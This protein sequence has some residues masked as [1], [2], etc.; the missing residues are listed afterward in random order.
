MG[1]AG[2][3]ACSFWDADTGTVVQLSSISQDSSFSISDVYERDLDG[4]R[5]RTMQQFQLQITTYQPNGIEQL[6]K[7]A[8]ENTKLGFILAG[9]QENILIYR[10]SSITVQQSFNFSPRGRTLTVITMEG[11]KEILPCW[12]GMNILNG[13][14]KVTGNDFGWADE[15]SNGKAD[16]YNI[17]GTSP[18]FSNGEQSFDTASANT[19]VIFPPD[20]EDYNDGSDLS[21]AFEFPLSNIKISLSVDILAVPASSYLSLITYDYAG[22]AL[23][24]ENLTFATT[25]RK[26]LEIV[27]DPGTYGFHIR[28]FARQFSGTSQTF[29]LRDPALR[30]D[31]LSI[32]TE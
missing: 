4:N 24:Q 31:G 19:G 30:V 7:W 17:T 2:A 28:V 32:Y 21:R 29:Q 26:S 8:K 10:P 27:T 22:S 1:I 20:G 25:G 12:R 15:D 6:Q 3:I 16:G 13:F 18:A 23:T 9:K 5:R 11:Q 14:V